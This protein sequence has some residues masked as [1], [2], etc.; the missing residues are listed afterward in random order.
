MARPIFDVLQR[1]LVGVARIDGRRVR[2]EPE[3]VV[4]AVAGGDALVP[5]TLSAP[6]MSRNS[7]V[8]DLLF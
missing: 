6:S 5:G 3:V 4:V 1:G 2:I 8:P 7:A